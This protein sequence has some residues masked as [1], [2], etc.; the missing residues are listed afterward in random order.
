[1][2]CSPSSL[3]LLVFAALACPAHAQRLLPYGQ[4][5]VGTL[6]ISDMVIHNG[7]LVVGG[8]FSSFLGNVRNNLQG[9]DGQNHHNYV[10]AFTGP[11]QHVRA[12]QIFN[13]ELV[14]AGNDASL[15]H[16]ARWDGATWQS[17]GGGLNSTVV[18]LCQHGGDLVAATSGHQVYRLVGGTWQTLGQAFDAD[19]SALASHGGEL[20]A[21]G[22]F[23]QDANSIP[24][25]RLVRWDGSA[26]QE[27][28]GGLN[29]AARGLLSTNAGLVVAGGFTSDMAGTL[30]LPLWTIWDGVSFS[31]P[32]VSLPGATLLNAVCA[33]PAE[34]FLLAGIQEAFWVRDQQAFRIRFSNLRAA[35]AFG[36]RNLLGGL[37][38]RSYAT[39]RLVAELAEGVDEA[40]LDVN[41]V[42]AMITPSTNFFNRD[43]A[44]QYEVPQGS[45]T[46]A[47][48]SSSPW[49]CGRE[50]GIFQ[51]AAPRFDAVVA[52]QAGPYA[53]VMDESFLAKY[54]QVW[55]VDIQMIMDH[56]QHW[57]DPGY[58][59]PHAIA[60][61]PGNGEVGNGEPAQ[62]AP[63]ADLDADGIYEPQNGEHPAF[64]GT[65]AV[66]SILHA[67][68]VI[69][70]IHPLIPVDLHVM[71][72][73]Y[74]APN[75]PAL[76]NSTMASVTFVNRGA[77][78]YE[79]VRMGVFTDF[80]L[81]HF[82]DDHVGCDSLRSIAYV[83]NGDAL[84]ESSVSGPGYGTDPPAQGVVLLNASLSAHRALTNSALLPAPTM[85]DMFY[86]LDIGQP[87]TQLGY[88]SH[89]EYPGGSWTEASAGNPPG[90]R[91]SVATI[92]PF[93]LDAGEGVCLDLAYVHARASGGG[94]S[95]SVDS[96]LVRA[97]AV[98]T[99]YAGTLGCAASQGGGQS[100]VGPEAAQVVI[101][102]N[103]AEDRVTLEF[104]RSVAGSMVQL[105]DLTGRVLLHEQMQGARHELS[106]RDLA[107]GTY[108]VRMVGPG[109]IV[110]ATL[111]VAH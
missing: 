78:D 69:N 101:Y 44:P 62:L 94:P 11:S 86:G 20:Y 53:T 108:H 77:T 96:L 48:F 81:G 110:S 61:W 74:D 103:P 50:Q 45:G 76:S 82:E 40:Y 16:V 10:G 83:Y 66:Y 72:Y 28:G 59:I 79:D 33:H 90:D 89:L 73:A 37:E 34:G 42:K 26:W 1:M 107:A 25:R 5:M 9:W 56:L 17:L 68:Q 38:G 27:V 70:N 106:T 64:P 99:W 32:T 31:E 75:D 43:G 18:A 14:A 63:F 8:G 35:L 102:P 23:V 97:E 52:P 24:F 85:E 88:P 51:V 58:I 15:G 41:E 46:H 71:H 55:K 91:R 92:G 2:K 84:D 57:N 39:S 93:T 80:D 65:Q 47:V 7:R 104:D 49:I 12:L 13:G 87:F 6:G 67:E 60:T 19:V 95:A 4:D 22:G 100:V 29:G 54:H 36:G 109:R 105:L 21:A 3:L 30:V 98:R 111:L